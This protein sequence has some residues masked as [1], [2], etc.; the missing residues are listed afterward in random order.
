MAPRLLARLACA[1]APALA[2]CSGSQA[3]LASQGPHAESTAG[4]AWLL[5]AGGTAIFAGVLAAIW[6]AAR[7]PAGARDVLAR[8]GMVL[9]MGL[10][11][12]VATLSGLL[13]HSLRT[14]A[15]IAPRDPPA[16]AIEVQG[17]QWWWRVHYLDDQGR[18]VFATA[19]EIR[20]PVGRSVELLLR[21]GDVIHSFWVPQLA[22]KLD[23]IPGRTN[24]LRI[25]ADRPGV[26]RGQC[27]EYCGGAH[28]MMAF[29]VVAEPPAEFEAWLQRQREPA[30]P[31]RDAEAAR[32]RD[33]FLANGCGL[34]HHVAGTGAMGRF[35]PDLTHVGGRLHL[36]SG[37][38]PNQRGSIA[39]WIASAQHV[40]PQ[41][42]MPSFTQIA[43]ADLRALAAWLEGLE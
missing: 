20:I 22:G 40:K 23:M 13:V 38:L 34:C 32:G 8:E 5:F 3:V 14:N 31:P 36:V 29:H 7:G 42:R 37:W 16:L 19:N 26:F 10:G 1:A 4:I 21:S 27:A 6:L 9:A 17:E 30:A 35:G 43:G 15:A 12:P 25:Q 2:G 18:P 24:R 33:V 41:N 11:L 39:G 28:A